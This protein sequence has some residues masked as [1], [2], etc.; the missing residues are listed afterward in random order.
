MVTQLQHENK[1]LIQELN[2]QKQINEQLQLNQQI[3][4]QIEQ[5]NKM[6]LIEILQIEN[7]EQKN[8]IEQYKMSLTHIV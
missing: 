8:I 3:P 2:Q 6:L 7:K 1:Q 4:H 5:T